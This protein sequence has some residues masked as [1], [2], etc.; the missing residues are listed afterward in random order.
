MM[1]AMALS[2]RAK[3]R[4]LVLRN[5][6]ASAAPARSLR[7]L[8]C[9][10]TTQGM[11]TAEQRLEW[12]GGA[13][14]VG[15]YEE[16]VGTQLLFREEARGNEGGGAIALH[17]HTSNRIRFRRPPPPPPPPGEEGAEGEAEAA[18][19]AGGGERRWRQRQQ[20]D[21]EQQQQQQ[22][23]GGA[24]Q[25]PAEAGEGGPQAEDSVQPMEM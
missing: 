13:A 7:T 22:Q 11:D 24:P 1:G 19:G 12:E 5:R 23:E 9:R 14:L 21:Q 16:A 17:C 8:P 20:Q 4:A 25:G 15:A 2:R 6:C 10:H 18:A 3:R